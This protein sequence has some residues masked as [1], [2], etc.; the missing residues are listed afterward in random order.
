MITMGMRFVMKPLQRVRSFVR[1]ISHAWG[2]DR[3]CP[4]CRRSSR[5]FKDFG[6]PT[7]ADAKCVRCGSL[8]RHRMVWLYLERKTNL[9]DGSPKRMLHVAPESCFKRRLRKHLGRGY[10]TG[11]LKEEKA[12]VRMDVMSIQYP[13]ESF[14]VVYCSHVLEHVPD[15]RRAMREFHRVLRPDGWAILLVPITREKTLEDPSVTDPGERLRLFG[16]A[17]H[18]RRYGPDY[19][20]RLREAGFEVTV[21]EASD[22][23][24][25][26]EIVRM[27]ITNAAGEIFFCTRGP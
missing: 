6:R 3:Y 15:D 22:F 14:D 17:D 23:L 16:Q 1:K 27:G 13:D 20:D 12:M 21:R 11:D 19:V 26:E 8:E 18:V 5:R 24:G 2:A 4:V 9:L 7:R 25:P 10:L